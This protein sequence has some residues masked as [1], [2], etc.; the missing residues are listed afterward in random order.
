[1]RTAADP[2]DF[3][4]GASGPDTRPVQADRRSGSGIIY[5]DAGSS[6][7]GADVTYSRQ[8]MAGVSTHYR[9]RPENPD[10][11]RPP[12][13]LRRS[14]SSRTGG[15]AMDTGPP[16]QLGSRI[17][18]RVSWGAGTNDFQSSRSLKSLYQAGHSTDDL[19]RPAASMPSCLNH[20]LAYL[21]FGSGGCGGRGSVNNDDDDVT[22]RMRRSMSSRGMDM[23]TTL[24]GSNRAMG[25]HY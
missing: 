15:T 22:M 8:Y 19:S 21:S 14:M 18:R 3:N 10:A 9:V 2:D 12:S 23:G 6:E 11:V 4:F 1:M 17:K 5:G 7:F 25:V 13:A 20:L 24:P 16:G